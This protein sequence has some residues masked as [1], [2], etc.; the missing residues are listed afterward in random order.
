MSQLENASRSLIEEHQ[1]ARLQ[2]GLSRILPHNRFY[3]EK[4]LSHQVSIS[5]RSLDDLSQ[6]PLYNQARTGC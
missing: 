2:L 5:L 1:L 4:L 6:L 3:E